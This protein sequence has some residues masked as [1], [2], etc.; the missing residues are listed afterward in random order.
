MSKTTTTKFPNGGN[1]GTRTT[2]TNNGSTT[3][4]KTS[5]VKRDVIGTYGTGKTISEKTVKRD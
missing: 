4:T 1:T 5:E 3:T 2:V